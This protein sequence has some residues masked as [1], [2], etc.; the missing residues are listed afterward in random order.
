M[1]SHPRLVTLDIGH[2]SIDRHAK[3][4][5]LCI[6]EMLSLIGEL[7]DLGVGRMR[8]L[9]HD[10]EAIDDLERLIQYARGRR[11]A[12]TAVCRTHADAASIAAIACA[13]PDAI[14]IPLHSHSADVHDA[15]GS[16]IEWSQSI[17]L[18]T[19]VHET[20]MPLEIET[21]IEPRNALPL[22]PL[23]EVVESLH[24]ASWHL[25]FSHARL[26]DGIATSAATALIHIA[27]SGR[28]RVSVHELPFLHQIVRQHASGLPLMAITGAADT[29]HVSWSG[30]VRRGGRDIVVGNVRIHALDTIQELSRADAA[31]R[32]ATGYQLRASA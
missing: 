9:L 16:E 14:A 28:L 7:A 10:V 30:D 22:M 18:A 5:P 4:E 26:S 17:H 12:T 19:A 8:F 1:I 13:R 20:G 15:V 6:D 32:Y 23:S 3:T 11:C 31:L 29:M 2:R 24:A 25:D 27:A 21:A